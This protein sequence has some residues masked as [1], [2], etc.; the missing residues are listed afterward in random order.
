M[1]DRS[2]LTHD[3]F[4]EQAG[5]NGTKLSKALEGARRF[6][7]LDLARI[8]EHCGVTVDWLITGEEPP[9]AVAAR[10]TSGRAGR[11][12]NEARRFSTL[13]T[14]L[15][16]LGIFRPALRIEA[17]PRGTLADTA[18]ARAAAAGY[19][20]PGSNLI[21]LVETVFDIDV[22]VIDAGVAD[23]GFDGL[24]ASTE[25]G[26]QI[27]LAATELPARQRFTLAHEL[28]HLLAGDDQGFHLDQDVFAKEQMKDPTEM[29]A[30]AFAAA[31]LMPEQ[32]LRERVTAP[33]TREAFATLACE[34]LVSPEALAYRLCDLR[35]IDAWARDQYKTLSA[36]RAA[37]L[38][39]QDD[40]FASRIAAA[41]TLR[42]PGLLV[43]DAY[44][45]YASG[46]ATLRPYANLLGVDV[47]ELVQS[48]EA[49]PTAPDA[50]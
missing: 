5:I 16:S 34:L 32:W 20:V 47:D 2:G 38:A 12:L 25:D 36:A 14:D 39:D 17:E 22:A 23:G 28:G 8:A 18:L 35:L 42:P 3:A 27:V 43:R 45:A 37:S 19:T 15:T 4:A 29:K 33:F 6:T 44:S 10:T 26:Q 11:A 31:F 40:A 30:N 9:L 13:R 48:L 46:K 1:I 50:S 41:R 49:G 21:E 7:S 24:A